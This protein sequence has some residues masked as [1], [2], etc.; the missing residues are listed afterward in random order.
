M[1]NSGLLADCPLD[2]SESSNHHLEGCSLDQGEDKVGVL[3]NMKKL[4]F[5]A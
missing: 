4:R 3:S 1:D 5:L 2:G